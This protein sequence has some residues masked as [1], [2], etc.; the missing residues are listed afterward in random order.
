[1]AV[2]FH[3]RDCIVQTFLANLTTVCAEM[4]VLPTLVR[5]QTEATLVD[6]TGQSGRCELLAI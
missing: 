2:R 5:V 1:M 4:A 6:A 3:P